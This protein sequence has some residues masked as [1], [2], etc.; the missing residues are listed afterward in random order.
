MHG[1][2][3]WWHSK[4]A[5]VI[6]SLANAW[7]VSFAAVRK[8][9]GTMLASIE[10]VPYHSASFKDAGGWL[11]NLQS[12]ALARFFVQDVV[13]PRAQRGDAVAI[14]T[15]Q[16]QAWG[17]TPQKGV[18]LYNQGQA[19]AAHLTPNSPGGKAIRHFLAKWNCCACKSGERA[20][21]EHRVAT[22]QGGKLL[23]R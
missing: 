13:L 19:R 3:D 11:R 15:R 18:V 1:G 4:L 21:S 17:I 7:D 6:E 8:R 12:V 23:F 22:S 20:G 16:V 2:F 5:A 9:L 10:L 14:V